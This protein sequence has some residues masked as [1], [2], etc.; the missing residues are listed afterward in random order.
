MIQDE[1]A[2]DFMPRLLIVRG[3]TADGTVIETVDTAYDLAVARAVL[4]GAS[5]ESCHTILY[6]QAAPE[7]RD[8]FMRECEMH[9]ATLVA[10]AKEH[11]R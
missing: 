6:T 10:E 3:Q 7:T 9:Y 4:R 2:S 11:Y 8:E 5:I 1:Y